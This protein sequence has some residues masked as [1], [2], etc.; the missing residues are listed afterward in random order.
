MLKARGILNMLVEGI[1]EPSDGIY[2]CCRAPEGWILLSYRYED[3]KDCVDHIDYWPEVAKILA[4]KWARKIS[5]SDDVKNLAAKF[6]ALRQA[7]GSPK[8]D[9]IY[10]KIKDL[11]YAFPRGRVTYLDLFK[12]NT[13]KKYSIQHGNDFKVTGITRSRIEDEFQIAGDCEW[14]LD[15]HEKCMADERD[16]IRSLLGIKETWPAVRHSDF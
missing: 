10:R 5:E 16:Q 3:R 12:D 8:A 7:K 14:Q 9:M 13:E 4:N 11:P 15:S 6:L 1:S 2:Y